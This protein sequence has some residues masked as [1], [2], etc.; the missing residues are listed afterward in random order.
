[1]RSTS[2][3]NRRRQPRRRCLVAG[4]LVLGIAACHTDTLVDLRNPDLIT[5]GVARDTANLDQLYNGVL[6]EFGRAMTGA[7]QTNDNPGIVGVSGMLA[8]ELWYSSTFNTMQ[9]IDERAITDVSNSDLTLVFQ[10]LHLARNLADRAVE[11]FAAA[12]KQT[13]D[14]AAE[15]ANLSGFSTLFLAENFCS[16]VP[17]S[18]TSLNG[19]L[20]FGAAQSTQQLLDTAMAH[21]NSALA[22]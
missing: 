16:G 20:V 13:S 19:D 15:A 17:L 10:R 8:D 18:S 21:F 22:V 5:G 6:F 3:D 4:M 11:Q 14:R 7:A 12:G 1:M 2:I 9:E